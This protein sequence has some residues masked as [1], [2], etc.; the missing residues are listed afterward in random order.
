M[1]TSAHTG[2][3]PALQRPAVADRLIQAT[4]ALA[5]AA[6]AAVAAAI[7]YRHAYELVT[8]HGETG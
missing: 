1:A 6:V 2:N 4:T 5:V 3:L 8:T 7:S